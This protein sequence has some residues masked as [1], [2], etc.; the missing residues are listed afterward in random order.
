MHVI[1]VLIG[2]F[3]DVVVI[4]VVGVVARRFIAFII[5]FDDVSVTAVIVTVGISLDWAAMIFHFIITLYIQVWIWSVAVVAE[6]LVLTRG[7]WCRFS[8]IRCILIH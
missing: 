6:C 5:S 1:V 2:M 4:I 3:T 7:I 8:I